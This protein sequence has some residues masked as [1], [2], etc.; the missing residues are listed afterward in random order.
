L[1]GRGG[2]G[3][4]PLSQPGTPIGVLRLDNPFK[5]LALKDPLAAAIR[6]SGFAACYLS[7]AGLA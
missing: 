5:A 3:A 6:L 1:A 7:N 2:G 4:I